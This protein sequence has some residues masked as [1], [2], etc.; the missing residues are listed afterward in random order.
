MNMRNISYVLMSSIILLATACCAGKK[1]AWSAT[2]PSD[3]IK[4][5]KKL[6][7]NMDS[8]L[9]D[10]RQHT[11]LMMESDSEIYR[12]GYRYDMLGD[13]IPMTPYEERKGTVQSVC[14]DAERLV[15]TEEDIREL[16]SFLLAGGGFYLL[17]RNADRTLDTIVNHQRFVFTIAP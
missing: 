10:C 17:V 5:P 12:R 11:L 6:V 15:L 2:N 9:E 8:L 3:T 1:G 13:S 14:E 4:T 7:V 16:D